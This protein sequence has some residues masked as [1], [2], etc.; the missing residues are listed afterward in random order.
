MPV[1]ELREYRVL[2]GK[3]DAWTSWMHSELLPYMREKGMKVLL[4]TSYVDDEGD[5]WFI[6]LREFDNE[7]HR[8]ALYEATYNDWWVDEIRPKI[9]Q[10]IEQESMKVRVLNKIDL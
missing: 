4:T 8:S 1:I 6:W 5:E 2:P 7:E 10:H 9:F 3:F